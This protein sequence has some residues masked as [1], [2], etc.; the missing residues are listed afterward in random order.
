VLRSF[1]SN[2]FTSPVPALVPEQVINTEDAFVVDLTLAEAL[3]RS[4]IPGAAKVNP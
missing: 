2:E 4:E 3:P 1:I